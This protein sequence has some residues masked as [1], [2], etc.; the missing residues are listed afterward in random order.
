MSNAVIQ[1]AGVSKKFGRHY[2]V[3]DLHLHIQAGEIFGFLGPNGAGKTTTIRM[4]LGLLRPTTGSIRVLGH[5]IPHQR[6]EA[7]RDIAYLPGEFQPFAEMTGIDYL[8]WSF[9]FKRNP[10]TYLDELLEVM[11]FSKRDLHKKIR[12]YSKGMK[13]KIGL[14]HALACPLPLVVLDEPSS[15]L[16]PLMQSSFL[17][18]VQTLPKRGT[19]VFFSS[20]NLHEVEKIC[21]RVGIIRKGKL[22]RIASVEAL[23]ETFYRKLYVEFASTPQDLPIHY[24][25]KRQLGPDKMLYLTREHPKKII[26]VLSR[27]DIR[28]FSYREADLE[29]MFLVLY[30]NDRADA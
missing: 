22:I 12:Y 25:Q 8:Q 28:D 5:A 18:Y 1:T 29:E 14:I 21:H 3:K 9:R 27:C 15:G 30:K 26:E 10:P 4:L 23:K 2:A 11:Q 20:H 6:Y 17:Q 24:L 7:L 13:Q 19:T 16:D